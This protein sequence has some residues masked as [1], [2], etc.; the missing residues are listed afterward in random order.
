MHTLWHRK[1][2][3]QE[4]NSEKQMYKNVYNI[5]MKMKIESGLSD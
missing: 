2:P 3:L 5:F 4:L 1:F